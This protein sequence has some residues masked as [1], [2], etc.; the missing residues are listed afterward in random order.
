MYLLT[1][2]DSDKNSSNGVCHKE[3][4]SSVKRLISHRG[5]KILSSLESVGRIMRRDTGPGVRVSLT[6]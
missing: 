3:I 2:D 6:L 5:G 1:F 4:P